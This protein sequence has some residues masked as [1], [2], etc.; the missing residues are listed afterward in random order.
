MAKIQVELTVVDDAGDKAQIS[1][2]VETESALA[3][4]HALLDALKK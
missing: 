1:T 2:T 4:L 3:T